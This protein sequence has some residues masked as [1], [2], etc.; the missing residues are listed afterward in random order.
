MNVQIKLMP[1]QR[2][3]SLLHDVLNNNYMPERYKNMRRENLLEECKNIV[4]TEDYKNLPIIEEIFCIYEALHNNI[5]EG[6]ERLSKTNIIDNIK[7]YVERESKKGY[8]NIRLDYESYKLKTLIYYNDNNYNNYIAYMAGSFYTDQEYRTFLANVQKGLN[9]VSFNKID[10]SQRLYD[11]KTKRNGYISRVKKAVNSNTQDGYHADFVLDNN[12]FFLLRDKDN[13]IDVIYNWIIKNTQAGILEEWKTYL[14]NQLSQK[15]HIIECNVINYTNTNLRGLVLSGA[16]DT[17][18]IRSIRKEGMAIGEIIIPKEPVDLDPNMTFIDAM[19]KFIIPHVTQNDHLY[20]IGDEMSNV[21]KSPIIYKKDNKLKKTY[22][23]ERQKVIAQG[24]LNAIKEGRHNQILNGGMGIGKTYIS[25]M[26]AFATLTE[27]FKRDYGR[28][29][30]FCQ[31]HILPKWERQFAEALP[32][33]PLKFIQINNYKDVLDLSGKKPEGIEVYLLPKDRVKRSYLIEFASNSKFKLS[34]NFYKEYKKITEAKNEGK[35]IFI[36]NGIKP[37]EMKVFSRRIESTLNKWVCIAKEVFDEAENVIGYKITT[38]SKLLKEKFGKTNKYYDF[39]IDNLDKILD[40]HEE[41]NIEKWKQEELNMDSKTY[42]PKITCPTCGGAVFNKAEDQLS[43]DDCNEFLTRP[44]KTKSNRNNKCQNY[45]KVDGTPLTERERKLIINNDI[46]YIISDN[47]IHPYIDSNDSPIT[48]Q[49]ELQAIKSGKSDQRYKIALKK[50]DTPMWTAADR[51]GYRTINSIDLLRK[52][53]GDGFIDVNIADESHL[54]S[55][56][57]AQGQAFS[58]L[59]KM[60]KINIG[61]TGTLTGGK[62]SHMFYTLY[63]MIPGKMSRHYKYDEISKFIDHYGRRKKVTK[64]YKNNDKYNQSGQG[65]VSSSG[66]NE[67]PGIS[68]MLYSHFLSDIMISRKIENMGFD[69]P[70]LNFFKYD[71]QM[72]NELKKGYE[73]LKSDILSF[74]KA[75]K[76]INLG[77]TYLNALLSYPD[78]PLTK[79]LMYEDSLIHNPEPIDI[80]N[81][82]L[83]KEK[84]LIDIIKRN[85]QEGNRSLVYIT[86]TGEKAVD[87]RVEKVLSKAGLKVA[88]LKSSVNTE[89]REEWIDKK[90]KEG[91]TVILTNPKI[92]QTGLDIV[93]YP[94][95]IFFQLDYDVRVV[96]QAESRAWR[97]GQDK[98]CKVYYLTYENTIQYDALKLIGSKKKA[99]LALEGVFAEDILSAQD[100]LGDSGAA[101]L[102]KS[103]LGK[104]K[105]KE[106]DLDFFSEEEIRDIEEGIE[107]IAEE[108][109]IT[110]TSLKTIITNG[111]ISLFTMTK[112]KISNSKSKNKK[113]LINGQVSLFDI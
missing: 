32:N 109:I 78:M 21:F 36:V 11:L 61:L 33:I 2:V 31:S 68:P 98:E 101:T 30:I 62:A 110:E 20:D 87:R 38:T 97:V 92:V 84:K 81:I 111:Q 94:T 35:N 71:V 112:E 57:S 44:P 56:E 55:S 70:E 89:K 90:Y 27:Y 18:L 93:Q 96:R 24:M 5:E 13:A 102:Y 17:D 63:R 52:R 59:C 37:S 54:Y 113:K 12:K 45:I 75:N 83:P 14:Y 76:D 40:L 7:D 103:L 64:L 60:S 88:V 1:F 46:D 4:E 104:I 42:Y 19:T 86:Y 28:I 25:V 106:D 72:S 107:I 34:D 91:Y 48:D 95:I 80:E 99:S 8:G 74:M 26:L 50:C 85:L 9:R 108:P 73:S 23:Y 15:G 22:L 43:E 105:L 6:K 79:P 53:F 10:N 51:K 58:N 3:L 100:D 16:V 29:S 67:I 47:E 82:I 77:G 66:W 65:K 39:Q 41:L 49:E 69:M